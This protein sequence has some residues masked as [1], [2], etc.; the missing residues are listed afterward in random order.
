MM[1]V[2]DDATDRPRPCGR[3][4]GSI[5][6]SQNTRLLDGQFPHALPDQFLPRKGMFMLCRPVDHSH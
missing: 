4:P 5:G 2:V 6:Q 1:L 3:I